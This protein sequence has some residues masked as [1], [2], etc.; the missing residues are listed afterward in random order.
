[1]NNE[2]KQKKLYE[3]LVDR[4][5]TGRCRGKAIKINLEQLGYTCRVEYNQEMDTIVVSIEGHKPIEV[6]A[7]GDELTLSQEIESPS[8]TKL[9]WDR[10]EGKLY[11]AASYMFDACNKTKCA[12]LIADRCVE[13]LY[14]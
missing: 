14:A 13:F 9:Y 7:L 3:S 1:M 6:C 11:K 5:D 8:E 12:K 2:T 4:D 10:F